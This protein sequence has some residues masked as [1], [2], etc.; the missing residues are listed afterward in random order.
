[1]FCGQP[2]AQSQ[3]FLGQIS[4][5]WEDF[6][7]SPTQIT[8]RSNI[9]NADVILLDPD[10]LED[11]VKL[12]NYLSPNIYAGEIRRSQLMPAQDIKSII[13]KRV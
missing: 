3:K 7:R 11:P 10:V 5:A 9:T 13:A 6:L 8:L 4:T 1:M 2:D 12:I